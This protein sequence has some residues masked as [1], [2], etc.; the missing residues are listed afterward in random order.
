[1]GFAALVHVTA[2]LRAASGLNARY[3]HI[4]NGRETSRGQV[5][6]AVTSPSILTRIHRALAPSTDW[7]EGYLL[8]PSSDF[9]RFSVNADGAAQLSIDS[10]LVADEHTRTGGPSVILTG[11]P[12]A[13]GL[14]YTPSGRSPRLLMLQSRGVAGVFAPV[15]DLYLVPRAMTLKDAWTRRAAVI[16]GRVLPLIAF[17]WTAVVAVVVARWKAPPATR[18]LESSRAIYAI[19]GGAAVLFAIGLWW[20]LPAYVSWEPDELLPGD[21]QEALDARFSSGWATKY[22][23]AHFAL[24]AA[25]SYPYYAAEHFGVIDSVIYTSRPGVFSSAA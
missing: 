5:D 10:V 7:W 24:L 1:M 22:P 23:P 14:K 3:S 12:H 8:I 4:S 19:L 13:L 11:G 6:A 18:E 25:A 15:P 16:A 2:T 21:I 9:Y 17:F 20:G